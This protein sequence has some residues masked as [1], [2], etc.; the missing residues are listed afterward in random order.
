MKTTVDNATCFLL[1]HSFSSPTLFPTSGAGRDGVIKRTSLTIFHFPFYR[2]FFFLS[3][4]LFS[5]IFVV[6]L[7]SQFYH[8]LPLSQVSLPANNAR[9]LHHEYTLR[10]RGSSLRTITLNNARPSNFQ[11]RPPNRRSLL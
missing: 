10:M 3:K 1:Y 9:R 8:P 11:R 7:Q 6:S 5:F 2:F 4:V